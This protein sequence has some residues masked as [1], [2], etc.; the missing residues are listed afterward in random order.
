M[1]DKMDLP[2]ELGVGFWKNFEELVNKYPGLDG[3]IFVQLVVRAAAF[4]A[5]QNA[6][7]YKAADEIMSHSLM[8]ALEEVRRQRGEI[9]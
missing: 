5:Y 1:K 8:V 4:M 3:S 9:E 6:P 2:E 7:S